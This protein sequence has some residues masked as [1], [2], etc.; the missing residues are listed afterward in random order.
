MYTTILAIKRYIQRG[1]MYTQ[2]RHVTLYKDITLASSLY[3]SFPV[4][5]FNFAQEKPGDKA[6]ET[7]DQCHI[8]IQWWIQSSLSATDLS[9]SQFGSIDKYSHAAYTLIQ[10]VGI[11]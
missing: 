11:G 10:S 6:N 9:E 4:F 8:E 7:C 3:S 1:M 2:T 5:F